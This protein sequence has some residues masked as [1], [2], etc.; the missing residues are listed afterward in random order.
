VAGVAWTNVVVEWSTQIYY[1]SGQVVL[2]DSSLVLLFTVVA[3]L[4]TVLTGG[5]LRAIDDRA[6]GSREAVE[7]YFLVNALSFILGWSWI[8]MLRDCETLLADGITR[9]GNWQRADFFAEGLLVLVFGPGLTLLLVRTKTASFSTLCCSERALAPLIRK[10]DRRAESLRESGGGAR[11]AERTFAQQPHSQ[12]GG[13]E[14]DDELADSVRRLMAQISTD[15]CVDDGSRH[16]GGP[17]GGANGGMSTSGQ[18]VDLLEAGAA[19]SSSASS[20]SSSASTSTP[21]SGPVQGPPPQHPCS[22]SGRRAKSS[23]EQTLL[24]GGE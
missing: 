24:G 18:G 6:K 14:Q 10:Q 8:V 15:S 21:A 4:V 11:L 13:G 9:G 17:R 19:V 16:G 3:C 23:R 20:Y 1:P 5:K 22:S 2:A 7:G 12:L